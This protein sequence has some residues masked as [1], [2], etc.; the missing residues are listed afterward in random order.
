[1][2]DSVVNALRSSLYSYWRWLQEIT[3]FTQG[4]RMLNMEVLQY[5]TFE[6]KLN[7]S[8]ECIEPGTFNHYE[9]KSFSGDGLTCEVDGREILDVTQGVGDAESHW[10]VFGYLAAIYVSLKCGCALLTYYPPIRLYYLA[11]VWWKNMFAGDRGVYAG[12]D[13]TTGDVK[14]THPPDVAPEA[15]ARGASVSRMKSFHADESGT[16]SWSNFSVILPK[17]GARLVDNVSGFVKSG[18]ILALMGP[19][20]AGKTTLLKYVSLK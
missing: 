14:Y 4:S 10:V 16:L 18:R 6:C 2:S 7:E 8:S 3:V 12:R 17:T 19:S 11:E 9:C 15:D 1:M 13:M 20:G 5:M